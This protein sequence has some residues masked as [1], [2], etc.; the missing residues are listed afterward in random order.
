MAAT[1][2]PVAAIALP[3][4]TTSGQPPLLSLAAPP[5]DRA[6]G[7]HPRPR[8]TTKPAP[9][10][11]AL[12]H[13]AVARCSAREGP[14]RRRQESPLGRGPRVWSAAGTRGGRRSDSLAGRREGPPARVAVWLPVTATGVDHS[15]AGG[16]LPIAQRSTGCCGRQREAAAARTPAD[17]A[18]GGANHRPATLPSGIEPWRSERDGRR[19]RRPRLRV[20]ALPGGGS[21]SGGGPGPSNLGWSPVGRG[22]LYLLPVRVLRHVVAGRGKQTAEQNSLFGNRQTNAHLLV[23]LFG[24]K[25]PNRTS[26]CSAPLLASLEGGP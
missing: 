5:P 2:V 20:C 26:F 12:R 15:T 13:G 14:V 9:T 3:T 4:P 7:G 6:S 25:S 17:R 8:V 16:R 21:H 11:A 23:R 22:P 18:R 10:A 24:Q 1:S 19:A